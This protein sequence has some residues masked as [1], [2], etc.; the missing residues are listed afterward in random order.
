MTELKG[1]DL[2]IGRRAIVQKN[3]LLTRHLDDIIKYNVRKSNPYSREAVFEFVL[4][5]ASGKESYRS[6]GMKHGISYNT[7]NEWK[8]KGWIYEAVEVAKELVQ[9]K[10]D[11]RLTGVI[12]KALDNLD[13][14]LDKGDTVIGKDGKLK[15][16][17][18]TAKDN[19]L[20]AAIAFDKRQLIRGEATSISD[21][22]DSQEDKLAALAEEFKKFAMREEKVV[23][24]EVL[25][26]N[27]NA[28]V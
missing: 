5:V 13:T 21:S 6:S 22:K 7:V 10:L 3:V 17:P 16:K 9:E 8:R 15:T 19:A 18:V 25:V 11:R 24:G 28:Q 2:E 26:E 20:I 23:E 4:D 27:T 14:A 1:N 12:N